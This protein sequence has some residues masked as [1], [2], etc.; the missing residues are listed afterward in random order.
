MEE[1]AEVTFRVR[2]ETKGGGQVFVVGSEAE[3]GNS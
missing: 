3:L 1:K 2:F